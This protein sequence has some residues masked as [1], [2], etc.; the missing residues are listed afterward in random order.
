MLRRDD[1]IPAPWTKEG[2]KRT[3]QLGLTMEVNINVVLAQ[4]C[5]TYTR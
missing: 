2:K 1:P 4:Y 5:N 3:E